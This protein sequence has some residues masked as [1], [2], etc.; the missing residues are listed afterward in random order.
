MNAESERW[1]E[2]T[3]SQFPHE[4]EALLY[5]RKHLPDQ[6]P[7]RAWSNFEFIADD[8]TVNEVDLLVLGPAGLYLVEIKSRPGRVSGDAG[9]WTWVHEGRELLVDNPVLAAN[10][11]AKK[12]KSL[13][14]RQRA[15]NKIRVPWIE[16]L[17]FLSA[18]G[19]RCGFDNAVA[20]HVCVRDEDA[21]DLPGIGNRLTLPP[22]PGQRERGVPSVDAAVARAL[23]RAV[24]EAG[25]RRSQKYRVV[26]DYHL[27][28][29][30]VDGPG[31]QDWAATHVSLKHTVR[32]IRIYNMRPGADAATRETLARAARRE[33]EILQDLVHPGIVRPMD[34]REHELGP[35][36]IFE[37]HADAQNLE[38]HLALNG[39]KMGL[40]QRL[41]L[42]RS[43]A[44]IVQFAHKMKLRHRALNPRC[45]LVRSDSTDGVRVEILNWQTGYRELPAPTSRGNVTGTEHL[46]RLLEDQ[47]TVY[48]APEA[49]ASAFPDPVLLDVFALGAIG[50]HLFAGRRPAESFVELQ[51]RLHDGHGL[52]LTGVVDG[53][54]EALDFLIQASTYPETISR[55]ASVDEF[56]QQLEEVEE[57]FTCPAPEVFVDP[58]KAKKGDRL[59]GGMVVERSLGT[60]AVSV[61]HLVDR[62]GQKIV[63]KV[64]LT[65]EHNPHL[66]AEGE[67]LDKLRHPGVVQLHECFELGDRMGLLLAHAG[68]QSLGQRLRQDGRLHPEL[69]ERW[70]QDLLEAVRYLEQMGVPHRDIKP[71]NLGIAP[72][73][74]GDELHLV[75]FDF[76][77]SRTPPE[78]IRA[79][80]VGYLDP[81]L[82][83][84]KPPRWDLNAERFAAAVTL[85]EMATGTV[86]RWGAGDSDP[87]S[88]D[89]EATIE[90]DLLEPAL[91]E[92]MTAFF[93]QALRRDPTRRFDN[94]EEMLAAW[95][96]IWESATVRSATAAAESVE[97]F[98]TRLRKAQPSASLVELGLSTNALSALERLGATLVQDLLAVRAS[99]IPRMRGVGTRTRREVLEAIQAAVAVLAETATPG[100]E[101]RSTTSDDAEGGT[102]R[103]VDLIVEKLLPARNKPGGDATHRALRLLLGLDAPPEAEGW[104]WPSQSEA[105]RVV[106]ITQPV[107]SIALT[108]ARQRWARNASLTALRD[109][110][111][112]LLDGQSGLMSIPEL[113]EMVLL[114]RG[115]A[116]SGAARH[117]AGLAVVRAATETELFLEHPRWM[118]RRI[119]KRALAARNGVVDGQTLADYA[120]R[121]GKEADGLALQDPLP[122]KAT[123][124]ERLLAVPNP[125][126][127]AP[128]AE[129]GLIHLA[130]AASAGAAVSS[131][132]ELYPQGMPALRAL[133][134]SQGALLGTR[135][136]SVELIRQRV[137]S[138]YPLAEPLPD[139][140]E[141]DAL[142]RDAGLELDWDA[143]AA[144][145]L[146]AYLPPHVTLAGVSTPPPSLE[147]LDTSLGGSVEVTPEIAQA[148]QFEERLQRAEREGAFLVLVTPPEFQRRAEQELTRRFQVDARSLD[149]LLIGRM[150]EVAAKGGAR[151]DVVRR[152]DGAA[153]GSRDW[154]NLQMLVKR[155]VSAVKASLE[156]AE[157]TVLLMH[158][159]LLA[160]YDQLSLLEGL[161]DRV[162][163]PAPASGTRLHG[164]W[165]LVVGDD[166][167]TLPV[168]DGRPVPV[169]TPGEWARIPVSW[170]QNAHRAA[171]SVEVALD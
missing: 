21:T 22:P 111:A 47:S 89:C 52:R 54:P 167:Q 71:D 146:G 162:G 14:A 136:L 59:E 116:S 8:G 33:F 82:C 133:R 73:G 110:L 144:R 35:A 132:L 65:P 63:L 70:G 68:D 155:A 67:I 48:L 3:P 120:F 169:L 164:L 32:R 7:Y 10:R 118:V 152:A 134:L 37:H 40:G 149:T 156:S 25:I 99:D 109:E 165:V 6:E 126:G 145:G 135:Q 88:I 76:S 112:A 160:R 163:R 57:Q 103:S 86:P 15:C 115:S 12:L 62:G 5:L 121:L 124:V 131:R 158:P 56:L 122:A 84:R 36:L 80:T 74:R 83:L 29:L 138:R 100:R 161:R 108:K 123:V 44:E 157:R 60:G 107:L 125:E 154:L 127:F 19:I 78:R 17:V 11:K 2:I 130:A 141:L 117:R 139:P 55:L 72:R 34:Y 129:S 42:L 27:D 96:R 26:G 87:A 101:T 13:L 92:P 119:G 31:Y 85:H 113:A 79:G 148:R 170:L 23:A 38:H 94:A 91:R 151:W 106:G 75:L 142:L 137:R 93:E 147:R 51:Q 105:A 95:R 81:F 77:L 53:I 166:Q 97:P 150:K 69:L 1:K 43:L 58:V 114:T 4:H 45:I 18:Q 41:E 20:S 61:V 28:K 64:A 30:L 104:T 50:Y 24:A 159:G 9:T 16:E 90:S 102:A 49:L 46:D 98:E 128:L 66:K 39:Q 140:P 168:V 143:S 153:A 171:P